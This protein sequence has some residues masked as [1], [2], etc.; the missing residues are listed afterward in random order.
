MVPFYPGTVRCPVGAGSQ[1]KIGIGRGAIMGRR[2][3]TFAGR[4]QLPSVTPAAEEGPC[5]W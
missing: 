3:N 4:A 2:I 1:I 5:G